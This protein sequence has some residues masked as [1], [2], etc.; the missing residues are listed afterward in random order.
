[1]LPGIPKSPLGAP[2]RPLRQPRHPQ[3]P[4]GARKC[5][6]AAADRRCAAAA[7]VAP[8]TDFG[9]QSP[10]PRVLKQPLLLACPLIFLPYNSTPHARPP[11]SADSLGLR[12]RPPTP[13]RSRPRNVVSERGTEWF[14]ES[15]DF[16]VL[17]RHVHFITSECLSFSRFI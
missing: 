16:R 8:L 13:K 14:H 9:P 12:P 17:F 4:R 3:P 10:P 2:L 5:V 15:P 1:M 6:R 7:P 11:G